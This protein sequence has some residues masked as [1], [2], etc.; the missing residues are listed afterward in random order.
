MTCQ[1]I[2]DGINMK[3]KYKKLFS[4]TA[5]FTAGKFISKLIVIFMLPLY[6]SCLTS[7]EYSTADLITNLCNL[8]IPIAC[9]GVSEGIFRGAAE[10]ETDKEKFFTNGTVIMFIGSLVFLILSPLLTLSSYFSRYMWLIVI[11]V[12][13][14]NIHSVCS[15]YVCA[16]GNSKLFAGQ[17]V[18]NTALTV[19]LNILFLVF[20]HMGIEGYVLSVAIADLSS[21]LLLFF[22]ARLYKSFIP[23]KIS[24][25]VIK[26]L[27]KFCL[28]LIPSTVFWW[29]TGVSDRYLVAYICSD[30]INGLYSVAY[31]I[32]TLL[33]YVVIIFNDA[34]KLSAIAESGDKTE[35][36]DF[37]SKVFRYYQ[38]IMFMGGAFIAVLAP[39]FA[40]IL[41][42]DSYYM[43]WIYVPILS[44]ATVFTALDTFLGSAYFTVKR[45]GMSLIT[46][47]IGALLNIILNLVMIPWWGAMGA[48]VATFI[49]YFAVFI[50]RAITMH[51]F[52]SFKIYPIKLT[53]NTLLICACAT[54]ITLIENKACGIALAS[55][56][57]VVCLVYNGRDI[58]LGFREAIFSLKSRRKSGNEKISE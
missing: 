28:P 17:G 26:D 4:N 49:S 33:T 23:E 43:A 53:I 24:K 45:T 58:Y 5:I 1:H 42:A 50:I 52:I 51:R 38:A 29:I 40:K 44:A 47:L 11:Y 3:S 34:W 21:A 7:A 30:E 25:K 55:V 22:V 15:Q 2:R 54:L 35:C 12:L 46:A 31:K 56:V 37:Y 48:S 39:V 10:K 6:T 41:F 18:F 20:L 32:P 27:M 57:A 13:S 36:A 16:T 19:L 9:L 8:I 14:S